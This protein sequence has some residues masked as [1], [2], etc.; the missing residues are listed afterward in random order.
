MLLTAMR[1]MSNTARHLPF[2]RRSPSRGRRVR[3]SSP[4]VQ[5]VLSI[6]S[7][8]HPLSPSLSIP[9][10]PFR[11]TPPLLLL[12]ASFYRLFCLSS[13]LRS[14]SFFFSCFVFSRKYL[15]FIV[16]SVSL[17]L[18]FFLSYHFISSLS[19]FRFN[20]YIYIMLHMIDLSILLFSSNPHFSIVT[21]PIERSS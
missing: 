1:W 5:L 21:N 17:N 11:T 2:S 9:A 19:S 16:I 7:I 20:V 14:F 8:L 13:F 15:R 18:L 12:F 10:D 6:S 4:S 3:A